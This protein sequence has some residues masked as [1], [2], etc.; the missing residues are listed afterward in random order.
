MIHPGATQEE[1][2]SGY[3][4]LEQ[5]IRWYDTSSGTSQRWFKGTRFTQLSLTASIPVLAFCDLPAVSAAVAAGAL[6]LA[7]VQELNQWQHN[8]ITYRSTAEAL[9][10]EKYAYLGAVAPY[11]C[12][13]ADARRAI[14]VQRVESLIS[15]EHSKWVGRLQ[16]RAQDVGK[17]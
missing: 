1:P 15:T 12:P 16:S 7:A 8:W 4:R 2:D 10:H 6:V 11:D 9:R 17:G 13:D 5:Q 14:L 3:A